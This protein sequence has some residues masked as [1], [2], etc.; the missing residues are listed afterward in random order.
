MYPLS[1]AS[2]IHVFIQDRART[3]NI[4]FSS[5]LHN[6][7]KIT[8]PHILKQKLQ[9]WLQKFTTSHHIKHVHLNMYESDT[10]RRMYVDYSYRNPIKIGMIL[11]NALCLNISLLGRCNFKVEHNIN[12]AAQVRHQHSARQINSN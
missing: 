10:T 2:N 4:D 1:A 11:W 12:A 3:Q 7:N 6:N 5:R 9:R 8:A